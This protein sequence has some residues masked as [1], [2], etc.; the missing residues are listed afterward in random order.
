MGEKKRG[1]G[2]FAVPS[3]CS[4]PM[5]YLLNLFVED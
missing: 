5:S 3:S 4:G 1:D 2:G